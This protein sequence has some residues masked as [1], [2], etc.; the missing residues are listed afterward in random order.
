MAAIQAAVLD[1]KLK[2][3]NDLAR[4]PAEECAALRQAAG[5]QRGDHA[6]DRRG[7]LE[8]LQPVRRPRSESRRRE[9]ETGRPRKSARR[10][11]I[12]I[13]LHLQECF[14]YLNVRKGDL[15]ESEKA[16]EDVLALP[17]YPELKEEQIKFVAKTLLDAVK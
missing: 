16:C 4:G 14:A 3:L 12:R 9:A 10:S 5:G 2:Y 8:H 1:V 7:Q 6:E 17:V 15:P 11:T 13:P